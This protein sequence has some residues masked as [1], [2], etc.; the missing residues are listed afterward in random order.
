MKLTKV[1]LIGVLFSLT[2]ISCKELNNDCVNEDLI[3][4]EAT[5]A[6][7]TG[8]PVCG[9]NGVTY[10]NKAEAMSKG[11]VSNWTEGTCE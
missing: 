4:P 3:T 5:M 9:C 2:N 7:T 6:D 10:N 11:G 8:G 1:L